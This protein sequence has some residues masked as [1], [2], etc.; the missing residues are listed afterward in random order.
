MYLDKL[1]GYINAQLKT[2]LGVKASNSRFFGVCKIVERDRDGEKTIVLYDNAGNDD[3]VIDD[4]NSLFVY[5]RFVGWSIQP[6]EVNQKN[7]FGD[8]AN[9]KTAFANFIMGVYGNRAVL[10]LT[11]QELTASVIFNFPDIVPNSLTSELTGL[12]QSM[13]SPLSTNNNDANLSEG[14]MVEKEDIFFTVNY[15]IAII[16]DTSCLADCEIDCA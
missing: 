3:V 2:R 8:G 11:D 12:T 16:G 7:S 15:R 14:I 10:N 9:T 4:T 1:V 6:N 13:I 5:H